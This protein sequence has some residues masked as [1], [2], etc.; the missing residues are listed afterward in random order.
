MNCH[1][2][3]YQCI[4]EGMK[5]TND[6]CLLSQLDSNDRDFVFYTSLRDFLCSDLQKYHNSQYEAL[7]MN[8]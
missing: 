8:K 1:L 4:L 3:L 6:I 2:V 7:S 5:M